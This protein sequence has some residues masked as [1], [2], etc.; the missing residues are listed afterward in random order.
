MIFGIELIEIVFLSKQIGLAVLGASS[1]WGMVLL[2]RSK[3]AK[4]GEEAESFRWTAH[5]LLIP[6]AGGLGLTVFTWIVSIIVFPFSLFAHE[7][8]TIIPSEEQIINAFH[9]TSP[10]YILLLLM[11]IVVAIY[12]SVARE[13][14]MRHLHIVFASFFFLITIFTIVSFL[15]SFPAWTG[16]FDNDQLFFIGHSFHSIFTLGTVL[17]LDFTMLSMKS[18]PRI[19]RYMYPFLPN[20]SKV[21]WVGLAIDFLSVWLVFDKAFLLTP[22]FY[23]M[24]TVVAILIM[25]GAFLSGP[26]TQKLISFVKPDRIEPLMGRWKTI[27]GF[28]GV[29]SITSWLTITIFDYLKGITLSYG[30]MLL[31]Y[32]AML[33]IAYVVYQITDRVTDNLF[34]KAR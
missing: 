11:A 3:K 7:G 4:S 19:Q 26:M 10:F 12:Y 1:L 24:Q 28:S 8:I 13:K 16:Q 32:V 22:K 29:I 31:V 34:N 17:V 15:I 21:I 18:L 25:N 27:A 33:S 14:F 5:N 9:M 6:F 2:H 30:E 23:F 20:I